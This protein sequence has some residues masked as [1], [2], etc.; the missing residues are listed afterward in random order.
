M[1][2]LVFEM[3][4]AKREFNW[5][6]SAFCDSGF[7]RRAEMESAASNPTVGPLFNSLRSRAA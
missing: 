1:E 2:G 6:R 4:A 7:G 5:P 3:S